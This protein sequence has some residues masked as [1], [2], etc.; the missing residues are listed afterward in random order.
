MVNWLRTLGDGE[1]PL[2]NEDQVSLGHL[3]EAQKQLVLHMRRV[4]ET[5]VLRQRNDSSIITILA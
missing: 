1:T 5:H 3:T 2:S 4:Y